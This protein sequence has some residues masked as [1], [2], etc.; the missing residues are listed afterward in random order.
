MA[1][2]DNGDDPEAWCERGERHIRG[3]GL[4]QDNLAAVACF[5]QAASSGHVGAI[6]YL[7][8]CHE[9]GVGVPKDPS[10]AVSQ[11]EEAFRRQ[12]VVLGYSRQGGVSALLLPTQGHG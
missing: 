4:A 6:R 8:V 9:L 7:G 3:D 10:K 1:Q 12:E 11:Y 2:V 5:E